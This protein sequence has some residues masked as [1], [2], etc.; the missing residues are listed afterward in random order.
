MSDGV[1]RLLRPSDIPAA[2][3]LKDAAGWNQTEQDWSNVLEIAP[4][5]CFGIECG[6]VLAATTTVV[7]Y[8]RDLAWIGMVLTGPEY[9]RRGLA[10]R[11]MERAIDY[12]AAREAAWIKLDATDMGRPLYL[13]LGFEDECAVER[14]R[15]PPMP[16]AGPP[17]ELPGGFD[18]SLDLE[19]FGTDRTAVLW[20]VSAESACLPACAFAMGR[21]GSAAAYFGPC[22]ARTAEAARAMV[23]WFAGNHPGESLYWDLLPDNT[24]AVALAREFGFEP[25]RR[26]MRMARLARPSPSP[27]PQDR[28]LLYAIAGF[29][30]G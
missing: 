25:V 19:A 7:C 21:P 9:R 20:R 4:E 13:Q 29:E 15:R 10:R 23:Q 16:G 17:S 5:G 3:R 1:L 26:L 14:W 28:G 6:G 24:E 27:L 22:V 2:M 12:A 30:F 11:L 18:P 8:G